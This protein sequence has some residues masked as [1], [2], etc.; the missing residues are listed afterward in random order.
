MMEKIFRIGGRGLVFISAGFLLIFSNSNSFAAIHP[1]LRVAMAQIDIIDGNLQE[2]MWRAE[3]LIRKAAGYQADMVCLPEAADLGWMYQD[4][5][6]NACPIPG[7]YTDFLSSLAGE[8]RIWISAG[9]LEQAGDSTFNTAVLI[10][11]TGRIVLKHRK[12]KTLSS[13]TAHLYDKGSTDDI[14]VVDTEFGR[15]G[16]TI[17]ADNF[18]EENPGKIVELGGWLLLTPHGFAAEN[19]DLVNNSI[20]FM[21]HIKGLAA[22][23]KLWVVGTNA[24]LSRIAGGEWKGFLHSGCSTV[25]GP[26]G[27]A[28][29]TGAFNRPDLIIYDIPSEE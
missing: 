5:R 20:E 18:D 14:K 28:V 13:L 22:S 10:D 27:K 21:N 7:I 8:L 25:A 2:N 26:G 16:L 9:C 17:C 11:R 23:T 29:A 15:I 4:A 24:C 6:R 1:G 12:I 19:D 3:D